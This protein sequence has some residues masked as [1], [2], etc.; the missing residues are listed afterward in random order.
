MAVHLEDHLF[1]IDIPPWKEEE[2]R[3]GTIKAFKKSRGAGGMDQW[4]G[5]EVKPLPEPVAMI[6]FEMTR[7]WR[8]L[9]RV[10]L[11]LLHIRQ[12]MLQK[13][14]RKA[15]VENLRPLSVMSVFWRIYE[16]SLLYNPAFVRW[17][18]LVDFEEVA[19]KQSAEEVGAEVAAEFDELQFLGALDYSK[20]YD[21]MDPKVSEIVLRA[22][23]VPEEIIETLIFVW[24]QQIRRVCFDSHISAE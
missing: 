13:P 4:Q 15:I 23:R 17:R 3:E 19:W 20:A 21:R 2:L 22:C 1:G 12:S 16:G 9:G 6:F 5:D 10:P 11:V 14:G 8:K 18:T 7:K 24:S